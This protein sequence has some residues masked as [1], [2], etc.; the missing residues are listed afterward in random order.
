MSWKK[1][2]T[3]NISSDSNK[4]LIWSYVQWKTCLTALSRGPALSLCL[5]VILKSRERKGKQMVHIWCSPELK[6][7]LNQDQMSNELKFRLQLK[8]M[9]RLNLENE[10]WPFSLW[11]ACCRLGPH[12]FLIHSSTVWFLVA[13]SASG[14]I[15]KANTLTD[16]FIRNTCTT[17][18]LCNYLINQYGSSAIHEVLITPVF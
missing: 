2:N 17:G 7:T 15:R 16:Q 1:I 5:Y 11:I 18:H 12:L 13:P 9:K 4:L 6:Q 8:S 10:K 14:T 3:D